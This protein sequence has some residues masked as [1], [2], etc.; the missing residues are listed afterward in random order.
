MLHCIV[1][2]LLSIIV[3]SPAA[4]A[5]YDA[6]A[7][8]YEA[9]RPEYPAETIQELLAGV[10]FSPEKII[11]DLGAGT[12]KL[13]RALL[14]FYPKAK[15]VM[16]EPS[17]EMC[18]VFSQQFPQVPIKQGSA[19]SIP[20]PDASV[21]IVL[22]G[23][24]FHWFA[25]TETLREIAR[26]L[27]PGGSLGL[28]WNVFDTTVPWVAQVRALL[29]PYRSESELLCNHDSLRWQDVFSA[30]S[31]FT[32]VVHVT[33]RYTYSGTLKNILQRVA[34]SKAYGSRWRLIRLWVRLYGNRRMRM[35]RSRYHIA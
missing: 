27:K 21:D 9:G 26:V 14:E 18:A 34:S 11:C 1:F 23:T 22:V 35:V 28:I 10:A 33:R 15:I 30:D 12:G 3:Q 24:A 17:Q 7:H 29:D 25:T 6:V 2:G 20:L 32:P 5:G 19:E 16:V 31:A 13:T 8:Q 4:G